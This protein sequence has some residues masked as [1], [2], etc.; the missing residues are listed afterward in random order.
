[1]TTDSSST[2][3]F[4]LVTSLDNQVQY[5]NPSLFHL[6]ESNIAVFMAIKTTTVLLA[7]IQKSAK[8]HSEIPG[9][10]LYRITWLIVT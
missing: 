2:A 4:N 10:S 1:M 5:L 6:L 9:G 3:L 7:V 8:A